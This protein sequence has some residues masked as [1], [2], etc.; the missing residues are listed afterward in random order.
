[1]VV[2]DRLAG[3]CHHAARGGLQR[4]DATERMRAA[5]PTSLEAVGWIALRTEGDARCEGLGRYARGAPGGR[6]AQDVRRAQAGCP[7]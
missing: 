6:Y 7:Q 2:A 4:R 5:A 1:M 3:R